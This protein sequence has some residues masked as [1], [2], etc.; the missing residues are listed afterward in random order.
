MTA[1]FKF[2]S[3]HMFQFRSA[4]LHLKEMM[5][6]ESLTVIQRY[7]DQQSMERV[8]LLLQQI[9]FELLNLQKQ[10]KFEDS[11]LSHLVQVDTCV[12]EEFKPFLM[13]QGEEWEEHI[14]NVRA[15][16]KKEIVEHPWIQI[17]KPPRRNHPR[18]KEYVRYVIL[19]RATSLVAECSRELEA[20]TREEIFTKTKASLESAQKHLDGELKLI[21]AHF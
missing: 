10:Y 6:I 12:E 13:Q 15:F 9:L 18:M 4:Q 16:I 3:K 7:L 19:S 20:K 8:H 5:P 11:F 14:K 21:T 2:Y 17:K 1:T